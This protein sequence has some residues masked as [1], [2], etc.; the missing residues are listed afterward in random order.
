MPE[1]A[2]AEM[3]DQAESARLILTD[4]DDF[5]SRLQNESFFSSELASQKKNWL[6]VICN[7]EVA[8][9]SEF[10]EEVVE[11]SK[12]SKVKVALL[13]KRWQE[14]VQSEEKIAAV[15]KKRL[16]EVNSYFPTDCCSLPGCFW[17]NYQDLVFEKRLSHGE[18]YTPGFK[19][20]YCGN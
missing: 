5:V 15:V 18:G 9:A 14:I 17:I 8:G 13:E 4:R 10:E 7:S 20:I 19:S 3:M 6:L 1:V 12:I 2:P 11:D 16:Q